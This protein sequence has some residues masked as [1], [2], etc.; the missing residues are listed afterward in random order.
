MSFAEW[1]RWRY[2]DRFDWDLLHERDRTGIRANGVAL[3]AGL[4]DGV[5]RAGAAVRTGTRLTGFRDGVAE[6]T[7]DGQVSPVKVGAVILATGGFDWDQELRV[8][9]QPAAQR[10][11]G[12]P[13][14]NAP[15][16][17]GCASPPTPGRAWTTWPRAGGCRC[18]PSRGR[19]CSASS[20][21]GR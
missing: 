15:P 1:D 10:A 7:H 9:Y 13:P 21:T 12:A 11:S 19:R 5:L 2:P 14:T 4:L 20:S 3:V 6:L 16:A 18:W 17:T 8:I